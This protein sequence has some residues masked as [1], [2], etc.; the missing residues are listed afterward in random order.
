MSEK[1]YREDITSV[2]DITNY[3]N[4]RGQN[5]NIFCVS[6]DPVIIFM[7]LSEDTM[8]YYVSYREQSGSSLGLRSKCVY[9]VIVRDH[10]WGFMCQRVKWEY[11]VSA[12]G[13]SIVIMCQRPIKAMMSGSEVKLSV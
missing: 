11:Y 8:W 5:E 7:W 13:H 2:L 3:F 12:R 4:V 1:I 9:C 6:E 10:N